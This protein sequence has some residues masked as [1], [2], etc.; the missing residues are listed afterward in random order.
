MDL[1]KNEQKVIFVLLLVFNKEL[2]LLKYI[3]IVG[4]GKHIFLYFNVSLS[5]CFKYNV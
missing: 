1:Q 4:R 2:S 3:K 5:Y